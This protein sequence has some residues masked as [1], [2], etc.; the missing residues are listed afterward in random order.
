MQRVRTKTLCAPRRSGIR[1][2]HAGA[3]CKL[4]HPPLAQRW[5]GALDAITVE[6]MMGA[7]THHAKGLFDTQ[8]TFLLKHKADPMDDDNDSERRRREHTRDI[9]AKSIRTDNINI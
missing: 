2:E 8:V 3:C 9:G 4:E 7:L 1:G 5:H 6:A